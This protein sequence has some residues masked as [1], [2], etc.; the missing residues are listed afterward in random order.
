MPFDPKDPE[1]QAAIAA[2]VEAAVAPLTAKRDE[3]LGE[4][5]KLRKSAEISPDQLATVEAERD[6]ALADLSVAQKA[7]KDATKVAE[8]AQ[9]QLADESTYTQNLL[10]DNGLVAELTKHGITNPVH[11]KAAQALLRAGVQVVADGD[12]RIVK[13]GD[14]PLGDAVKEW[15]AGDEG[16]HFVSA[17]NNAGGGAPGGTNR[18][19]GGADLSKLPPTER[20]T[21]A[22]AAL[23]AKH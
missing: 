23:A 4:V 6:K 20:I 12:K 7:A 15:A 2:A 1:A 19:A 5:K 18:G 8:A 10:I 9:K 16:K 11:L 21:L 17:P 22:R 14:K 13:F 3:L